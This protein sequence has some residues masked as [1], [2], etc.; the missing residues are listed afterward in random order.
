[1]R[2]ALLAFSI[3]VVAFVPSRARGDDTEVVESVVED[4]IAPTI[5]VF[6]AGDVKLTLGGLVQIHVA[7]Y[8][9]D[10]ALVADDDPATREGFRLRRARF[11]IDGQFPHDLELLLVLNPLVSDPESGAISEARLSWSFR[12]WLRL[13]VGADKVPFTRGELA[14]SA[15]LDTIERPL[16]TETLVPQRRLGAVVEGLLFERLSYVLGVMNA[17]EGY[18][19]GN[20][21]AG[22]LG[23]ARL[24]LD[25]VAGGL[26][27]SVGTGGFYEDGPASNTVAGSAD[28]RVSLAGASLMVEGLCD[29]ITPDDAPATS[30]DVED[31]I[32]RC[33]YYGQLSFRFGKYS[34]EPV[35]RVEWFDDN[36]GL[37]DAGDALL[38]SAGVNARP[39]ANLRLQLFYLGRYERESNERANDSVILNLQGQF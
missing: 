26:G 20:R 38:V 34:I 13:A 37:D 16:T 10:D 3:A 19:L 23:V 7:P 5:T 11:G 1:M 17:T 33:G 9:G 24:Q 22:F 25:L 18:E 21:F 39:H 6:E 36:T 4:D 14:S 15:A 35:A 30:P 28:L 29:Q 12:P 31:Q 32:T 2:N 27:L 8:V